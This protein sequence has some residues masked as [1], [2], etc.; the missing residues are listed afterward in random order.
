[1]ADKGLLKCDAMIFAP[2]L[3]CIAILDAA[4]LLIQLIFTLYLIVNNYFKVVVI[5]YPF[6]VHSD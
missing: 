5:A 1:M 3:N 4:N 2:S 6:S